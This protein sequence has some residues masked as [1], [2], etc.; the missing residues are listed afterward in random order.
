MGRVPHLRLV[1]AP[2]KAKAHTHRLRWVIVAVREE[3]RKKMK[4][5]ELRSMMMVACNVS[6]LGRRGRRLGWW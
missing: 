2:T 5:K 4:R 6:L 3:G 1:C